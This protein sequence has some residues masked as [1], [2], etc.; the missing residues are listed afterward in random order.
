MY[1]KNVETEP[2]WEQEQGSQHGRKTHLNCIL[3][4]IHS[5]PDLAS[6]E[7]RA[8]HLHKKIVS[9]CRLIAAEIPPPARTPCTDLAAGISAAADSWLL[10]SGLPGS[11]LAS[12]GMEAPRLNEPLN[13]P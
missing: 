8:F 7:E 6:M 2:T 9:G 5:L 12:P 11:S 4:H 13:E 10:F 3:Q 1:C